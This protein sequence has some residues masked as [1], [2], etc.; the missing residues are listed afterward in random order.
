[1]AR[2]R[3]T[4]DLTGRR[5]VVA[6]G[7]GAIGGAIARRFAELGVA[8]EV[9]D[10]ALPEAWRDRG[11]VVDVTDAAAVTDAMKAAADTL[12]GLDILVYAA[13]IT[14]PTRTVRDYETADWL[15]TLDINLNGAFYCA[16]AALQHMRPDQPGHIIM[17]ASIAGKE[18]NPAMSAYSAAKA[19]VIALTKS[20]GK[21]LAQTGIRAHAIAPAL[22]ETSLLAQMD[23]ATVKLN[24]SKIPMGRPGSAEDV[25]EL[26]AWLA[27]PGCN[28]STGAVHDLSGGRATY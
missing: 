17:L 7:G 1:M 18:G 19:G 16:R 14:G 10:L 22:I 5:A 26:S 11:R 2:S 20:L 24:L 6:G 13:G 28:F 27:S 23:E 15:R 3:N 4:Y 25:A 9:W 21:E 12:G 8:V